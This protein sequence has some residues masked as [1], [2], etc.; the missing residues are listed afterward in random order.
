MN[1]LGKKKLEEAVLDLRAIAV[2]R[3]ASL[4]EVASPS[5]VR[6]AVC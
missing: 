5:R 3:S 1:T 2:E 6:K 4:A